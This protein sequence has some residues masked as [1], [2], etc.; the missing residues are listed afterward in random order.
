[1]KKFL[2]TLLCVCL[3]SAGVVVAQPILKYNN[4]DVAYRLTDEEDVD[5]FHGLFTNLSYSFLEYT[6]LN[7]GYQYD[8]NDLMDVNTFQYGGGLYYPIIPEVHVVGRI[9]G[10]HAE[11]DV[12]YLGSVTD[13]IFYIGPQLRWEAICKILEING[14]FTW[15]DGEGDTDH[16]FEVGAVVAATENLGLNLSAHFLENDIQQYVM[17]IRLTF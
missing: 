13:D 6:F 12:D 14:A 16:E 11:A 9:G 3:F 4:L 17:G 15:Y 7:V 5:N 1:M 8:E 10:Q 2:A